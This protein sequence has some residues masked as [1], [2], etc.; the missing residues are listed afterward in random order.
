[1]R[2][3]LMMMLIIRLW[4]MLIV[5]ICLAKALKTTP[6]VWLKVIRITK[7][8]GRTQNLL[9]IRLIKP[10]R[11]IKMILV[12]TTRNLRQVLRAKVVRMVLRLNIAVLKERVILRKVHHLSTVKEKVILRKVLLK[13]V[14]KEEVLL[15]LIPN[16]VAKSM[17]LVSHALTQVVRSIVHQNLIQGVV[18]RR[19]VIQDLHVVVDIRNL[20]GSHIL[21]QERD[22]LA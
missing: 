21:D 22:M 18:V 6:K 2:K 11:S 17:A 1:M 3:R 20:L 4:L 12:K 8:L 15:S 14:V 9:R 10:R 16:Q 19:R 13:A 5:N 7:R